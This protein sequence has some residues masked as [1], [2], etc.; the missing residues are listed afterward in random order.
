[1]EKYKIWF[2]QNNRIITNKYHR[3]KIVMT[4]IMCLKCW[5]VIRTDSPGR[6]LKADCQCSKIKYELW[7]MIWVNMVLQRWKMWC[8]LCGKIK[9]LDKNYKKCTCMK[10]VHP[11]W[12]IRNNKQLL[13]INKN[14]SYVSKCLKCG[15][16]NKTNWEWWERCCKKCSMP[17]KWKVWDIVE[18][19][20]VVWKG[21]Y[22]YLM[23]CSSCNKVNQM[24]SQCIRWCEC[25]I[26]INRLKNEDRICRDSWWS[27]KS[28]ETVL[29]S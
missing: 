10:I 26:K 12:T 14:R 23:K 24:Q 13:R 11:I 16:R 29:C 4:K 21:K 3:N 17:R 27:T 20:M 5:T 18:K 28:R 7:S 25:Q 2:I 19:R 9:K 8:T 1:M 22:W 6:R 15:A